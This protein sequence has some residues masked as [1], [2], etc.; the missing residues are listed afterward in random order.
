[1][2]NKELIIKALQ[3]TELEYCETVEN[4][5]Y[6]WIKRYFNKDV[7]AIK[8][9]SECASFWKWWVNQWDNRNIEFIHKTHLNVLNDFTNNEVK[10]LRYF[11][12]EQHNVYSYFI[13]PNRFVIN[14]L[15]ALITKEVENL[16]E[17][18]SL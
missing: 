15:S 13:I 4:Y 7:I 3:I 6:A 16:K 10:L 11:F 5:G 2:T 8:A 12:V 14:D 1:M 18:Q 17:L 9:L